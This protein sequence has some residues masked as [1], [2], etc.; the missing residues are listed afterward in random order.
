VFY[1]LN[2]GVEWKGLSLNAFFQGATRNEMMPGEQLQG[3]LPWGRNSL[4]IFL[5]RWHHEDPL[6]FTS[7]WVPGKYP[8]SRDGFGYGPNKRV[9]SYWLLNGTY[10]RLK[11]VELS[12]LLPSAWMNAINVEQIRLFVNGLNL[13]TWSSAKEYMDPE[14]PLEYDHGYKY[15]IMANYNFGI[16]IIF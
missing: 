15:P 4:K 12:Y 2:L 7:P 8:I 9:S 1:S 6:D 14:R 5:D 11:N 3:P 13:Y 10:L 16:N